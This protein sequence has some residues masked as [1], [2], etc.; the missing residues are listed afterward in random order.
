MKAQ[1]LH[2]IALQ[3]PDRAAYLLQAIMLSLALILAATT[4]RAQPDPDTVTQ[5]TPSPAT[6]TRP[7]SGLVVSGRA[8]A[9]RE[10]VEVADYGFTSAAMPVD[11]L[12]QLRGGFTNREG[13]ALNFGLDRIVKIDGVVEYQT[14]LEL[15]LGPAGLALNMPREGALIQLGNNNQIPTNFIQSLANPSMTT[16]IQNNLDNRHIEN[17]KQLDLELSNLGNLS[18]TGVRSLMLPAIL[19]TLH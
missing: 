9:G 3:P 17:I 15:S 4:T 18:T 13:I 7:E 6:A 5:H 14:Q 10:A 1:S 12:E 8:G 16:V 2:C 11:E 19:Q